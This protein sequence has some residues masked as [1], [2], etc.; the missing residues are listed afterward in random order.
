VPEKE[1]ERIAS[2]PR[3]LLD[4]LGVGISLADARSGHIR[5]ANK[6]FCRILGYSEEELTKGSISFLELTHPDDRDRNDAEHQRL[7]DGQI[8]Q[9]RVDNRY[10]R[11]DGNL[12]WVHA[13][14]YAIKDSKGEVRWCSAAIE[15]ITATKILE[16]QLAA[17]HKV[18]GLATWNFA[19]KTN[20]AETSSSFNALFGVSTTA[21]GPSLDQLIQRVHPNDREDVRSTIARAL[22]RRSG[23]T[24]EYRILRE[25]GEVRWLREIATC[26]YDAAGEVTNLVG[27]TID[28]TD[29]KT[30]QESDLT[31]KP[32]RDIFRHIEAN[33]N[34]PLSIN[35][36][37]KRYGV[38]SRYV[39]KYFASQRMSLAKHIKQLRL[40]HAR[41]KLSNPKPGTTV[42][43]VANECGFSNLGHFAKDYGL[44]FGE[45][46]SET[47]ASSS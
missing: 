10:L 41:Q 23:Y 11:G 1:L 31:P 35:E 7:L 44:E 4:G 28:I 16:Q 9:Y 20:R 13:T 38:S 18:A 3:V 14:I 39:F 33:W 12:V 37:A 36:L 26:V 43:Q 34:Q 2:M 17:A 46:P 5:F 22:A 21:P 15:D 27:A 42:T 6:E 19:V 32:I 40:R 25:G 45:K 24:N 29:A 8:P 47:L 30:R